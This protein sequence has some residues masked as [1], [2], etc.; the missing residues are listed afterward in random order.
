V[1]HCPKLNGEEE[2]DYFM[3][4]DFKLGVPTPKAINN[5]EGPHFEK[6]THNIIKYT[7]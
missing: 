6:S 3:F 1:N 2:T 7:H 4:I 5:C